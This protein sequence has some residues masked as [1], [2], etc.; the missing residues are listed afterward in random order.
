MDSDRNRYGSYQTTRLPKQKK[1]ISVL[2]HL[3]DEGKYYRCWNC[4]F[5]NHVQRNAIG[6][7]SGASTE[8]YVDT[9][10]VTKYKSIVT[11]GCSFCGSKNYR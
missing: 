11:A 6:V 2:G 4:G 9:D 5:V 8:A 1:T 3:E 7:G 10:G